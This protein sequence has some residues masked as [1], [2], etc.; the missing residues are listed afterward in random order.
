MTVTVVSSVKCEDFAPLI[1]KRQGTLVTLNI[2]NLF[3][4]ISVFF[5]D[6]ELKAKS[7]LQLA[8]D[9]YPRLKQLA[10][11]IARTGFGVDLAKAKFAANI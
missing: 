4:D 8:T 7:V 10:L 9:Q 11:E 5:S 3:F 1:G 6:D 2:D